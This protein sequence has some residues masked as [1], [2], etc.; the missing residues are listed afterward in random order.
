MKNSNDTIMNRTRELPTCGAVPQK[1]APPRTPSC[2]TKIF[3]EVNEEHFP[4]V[5]SIRMYRVD[6]TTLHG[7]LLLRPH[8][9]LV[10]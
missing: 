4:E 6:S 7:T 2:R 10:V 5:R 9:D 3:D 1:T 8:I